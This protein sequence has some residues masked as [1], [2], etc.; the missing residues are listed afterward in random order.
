MEPVIAVIFLI[1]SYLSGY[2][3]TVRFFP[4]FK[5]VLRIASA[6]IVGT[7]ISVWLVLILSLIFYHFTDEAMVVGFTFTTVLLV[8][9]CIHQRALFKSPLGLRPSHVIFFTIA[10]L[11][12][13]VLFSSTFDYDVKSHL[14]K[15]A[16]LIWS[17]Y[18]FHIPL[19][20]SFSFG[21][22]LSL[23]HPL[24]AHEIVRYHFLFDFMV[25][26]EEKMGIPLDYAINIPSALFWTCLLISIYSLSKRLFYG[27]RFVGFVSVS[28]FLFN[29]SLTFIEFLN[30]YPPKSIEDLVKSWWNLPGY[31]AFG[32]WDGNIISA[33]WNWSIYTNQRH[34][35]FSFALV[36]LVIIHYIDE[37]INKEIKTTYL[38]K[39]FV[40]VM[41]GLLVLWQTQ[42][43]ICLFGLM[44]L[45]FLLFPER[46]KSL[47]A[48]VVAFLVALPQ[49]LWLQQSSPNIESHLSLKI[50]YLATANLVRFEI[51]PYAFLDRATTFIFAFL[52][53]WFFNLGL[54]LI[55]LTVSFF[56]VDWQRKKIFL[57]LLTIFILGNLFRFSPDV[58]TNHKFFN[59]WLILSNGFTA[60]L[61]YRLFC[62]GWGGRIATVVLLFFLTVSGLVDSMPIKNDS[63]ITFQ[64]VENQP[65]SKWA[66]E[67]TD[68]NEVFLT[69]RRIYH[70]V[71]FA[72]RRTMLG[73]P[74]FA[75][76]AGFDTGK[77]DK[78]AKMIYGTNS[79]DKLCGLLKENR[80]DYI[81]TEKQLE[82]NPPFR[83]NNHFF[84]ANFKPVYFDPKSTF[85][86]RVFA[87]KDMCPQGE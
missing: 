61:L 17:D 71:S 75:W 72:G 64:D 83:I 69:T 50:G 81:V 30:K 1:T 55:T 16:G 76:S 73:W 33:F 5:N 78:I 11:Y 66:L 15:V 77:R 58:A 84:N 82:E 40:G 85:R 36:V 79:K 21:N 74:Y 65:L 53:Y 45:F 28:L 25:G 52:R 42:A 9:F 31:V 3:L 60:Y 56:L 47:V 24:Y 8:S 46:R 6:Y 4:N 38:E 68:A 67:N 62:L 48:L 35:A 54:S 59:L 14:I 44:G 20:R 39:A 41:C 70:P 86:E 19:I 26:V 57:M 22:N 80:I 29:S 49:I 51:M 7:L 2:L 18:G 63:T 10:F 32:P 23:E 34:L 37:H 87:T 43:F 13:W 12:S 27:S